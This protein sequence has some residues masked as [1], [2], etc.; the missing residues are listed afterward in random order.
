M[1]K[2]PDFMIFVI[3]IYTVIN[4]GMEEND[5]ENQNIKKHSQS[6][7]TQQLVKS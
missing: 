1:Y 2:N 3:Y 4:L 6:I 7:N 5:A